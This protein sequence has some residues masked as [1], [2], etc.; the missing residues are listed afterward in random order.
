MRRLHIAFWAVGIIC[1]VNMT[2]SGQITVDANGKMTDHRE[3]AT[4]QQR[5]VSRLPADSSQ[6]TKL[7]N[8]D[9]IG[10]VSLGLSD[11][12]IIAKIQSVEAID[13]DTSLNGLQELKTKNVPD[14]VI[15]V[16][17]NPH[18][19]TRP[20]PQ[21]ANPNAMVPDEVGV[22]VVLD[23]KLKE[24]QRETYG[25]VV[26][27]FLKT[28][29]TPY[30]LN[31]SALSGRITNVASPLRLTG[32]QEIELIIKS[33]DLEDGSTFRLLKL[34]AKKGCRQFHIMA[35]AKMGWAVTNAQDTEDLPLTPEKF[36]NHTWRVRTTLSK[37]E[38]AFLGPITGRER[39]PDAE[40]PQVRIYTFGVD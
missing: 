30:G 20:A 22:Y 16:M 3:P 39:F 34:E 12:V 31:K 40:Q 33:T 37:G 38:Y 32:S 21:A 36:A 28:L 5:T 19:Y 1:L 10:M 23:G 13:F 35:F 24:L 26:P 2:A 25:F 14:S 7:T 8:Q 29:G 17:I 6:R 15:R 27:G 11:Q 18:P 4:P 9:V